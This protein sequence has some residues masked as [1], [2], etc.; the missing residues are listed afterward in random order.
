[1]L[2][3]TFY[4]TVTAFFLCVSS[5][6]AALPQQRRCVH[7]VTGHAYAGRIAIGITGVSR[8]LQYTLP[9]LERHV[10]AVMTQHNF[11]YDIIWSTVAN[12]SFYG[13]KVDEFEVSQLHPCLFSIESQ[14]TIRFSEWKR[15]CQVRGFT[16]RDGLIRDVAGK[17]YAPGG[18]VYTRHDRRHF[19]KYISHRN[20]QFRNYL[21]GF[22]SQK[23][24]ANLIRNRAEMY[25]FTYDAV[26]VIRPDVAFI[27]DIDFPKHFPQVL[28]YKRSIWIPDFQAFRGLNDR[29]AFGS[30]EVMLQ[31]LE[32]GKV[33][34]ENNSY[35]FSIAEGYLLQY[36][37]DLGIKIEYSNMRFM[38][39]RPTSLNGHDVGLIEGFDVDPKLMNLSP[40]DADLL[41]CA[42][43]E[44]FD[45]QNTKVKLLNHE[46]C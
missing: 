10:F 46:V 35:H 42:G 31:Y 30:Q 21:C 25:E 4:F 39:V 45:F 40:S 6:K 29:A 36:T 26:L 28:Q 3:L 27:R 20:Y 18:Q 37:Q 43:T 34:M 15:F 23:R 17:M 14:E 19:G 33:F 8:G 12:P 16:C 22:D 9:S 5:I 7:N 11:D 41:R 32:R 13:H 44:W 2:P 1:M 24:L 38:R